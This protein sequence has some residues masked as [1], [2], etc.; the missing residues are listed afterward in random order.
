MRKLSLLLFILSL[1]FVGYAGV[2]SPTD[3]I[4]DT[5]MALDGDMSETV[6]YAEYM[7]MVQQRAKVRFSRMDRNHDGEVSAE[8]YRHFWNKEQS[9]YY[10][11]KR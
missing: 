4:V 6:S 5:F 10:R 3:K 1:P 9:A 8:E 11:L 2:K 7:S